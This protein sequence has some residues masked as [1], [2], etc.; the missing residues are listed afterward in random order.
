M[1]EFLKNIASKAGGKPET[2]RACVARALDEIN[3]VL[4]E[5]D[6]KPKLS[7]DPA[8]GALELELPEQMPDERLALPA[9][10]VE[11]GEDKEAA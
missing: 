5:L 1:F 7:F 6:V 2:Q 9:P 10:E 8:T 11:L 4:A 3:A